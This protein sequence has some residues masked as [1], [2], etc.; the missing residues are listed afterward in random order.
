MAFY[1]RV[2]LSV[3][4]FVQLQNTDFVSYFTMIQIAP[5]LYMDARRA[6]AWGIIIGLTLAV[7]LPRTYAIVL[8]AVVAFILW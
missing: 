4:S 6:V 7:C 5:D 3:L 8:A 2:F 1:P